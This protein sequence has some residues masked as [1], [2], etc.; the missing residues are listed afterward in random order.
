MK[1]SMPLSLI[2]LSLSIGLGATVG[3][4]EP[5]LRQDALQVAKS[6]SEPTAAPEVAP[7]RIELLD[8]GFDAACAIPLNPHDRDRA[9]VQEV[10]ALATAELGLVTK[11]AGMANRID[12]WRRGSV[13]GELAISAANT[14]QPEAAMTFA[15]FA[16]AALSGAQRWQQER[17]RVKVAQAH[18]LIGQDAEAKRLE[19]GVGEP[20]QG[21]VSA[22]L[23]SRMPVEK[24]DSVLE[25]AER[26]IETKNFDLAA[27]ALL[28]CSEIAERLKGDEA[29]WARVD[30]LAEKAAGS[31]ARDMLIKS[32]LR[33]AEVRAEQ[34]GEAEARAL[35]AKAIAAR[36]AARWTPDMF[37]PLTASIAKMMVVTKDSA[38][39]RREL[40]AALAQFDAEL[41]RVA[42]IFRAQPLCAAAEGYAAL[43]DSPKALEVYKRAIEEGSRN[44]NARPRAEDLAQTCA[45]MAR[46]GVAPDEAAM[47]QLRAIRAGLGDP[48]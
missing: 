29:R 11:A 15:R 19:A 22:A 4:A 12:N 47:T 32:Y 10:V 20:E 45:S 41:T 30:A 8:L 6:A 43:G 2:V 40:D 39:A 17:V 34:G 38:G 5:L 25:E 28:L 9:R 42:D 16:E 33:L 31:V 37:V 35:V 18:A 46:A 3:A 44:P 7:F 26:M 36:D 1:T 23:A 14:G 24:I 27:N 13:F 48:W 21:K